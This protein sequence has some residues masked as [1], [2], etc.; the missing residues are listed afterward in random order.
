MSRSYSFYGVT[1]R[2]VITP[3]ITNEGKEKYA[4]DAVYTGLGEKTTT[5][6]ESPQ[7]QG[8]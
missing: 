2:G 3:L 8:N 7:S 6:P 4:Q 5:V 1:L